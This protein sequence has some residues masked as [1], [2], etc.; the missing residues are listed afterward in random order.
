ML[1]GHCAYRLCIVHPSC[2]TVN[3]KSCWDKPQAVAR[4]Q[5]ERDSKLLGCCANC[6]CTVHPACMTDNGSWNGTLCC[7]ATAPIAS[8][9]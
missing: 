1:P 5:Q 7:S 2:T 4:I 6:L 9:L 8:A 3:L